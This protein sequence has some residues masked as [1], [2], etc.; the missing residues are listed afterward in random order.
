MQAPSRKKKEGHYPAPFD[1]ERPADQLHARALARG[2]A[3]LRIAHSFVNHG[4][5]DCEILC[6]GERRRDVDRGAYPEDPAYTAWGRRRLRDAD[7]RRASSQRPR[8]RPPRSGP[9]RS[10]AADAAPPCDRIRSNRNITAEKKSH[11]LRR[12]S[13][14]SHREL[15]RWRG[16]PASA[17]PVA[18]DSAD[19]GG[20]TVPVQAD[21][22]AETVASQPHERCATHPTCGRARCV[23]RGRFGDRSRLRARMAWND[24]ERVQ[25]AY[26]AAWDEGCPVAS[27]THLSE[28]ARV[29]LRRWRSSARRGVGED[30][31]D[32]RIRDLADGLIADPRTA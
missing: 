31:R 6:F 26:R 28:G 20:T 30:D 16:S 4:T 25:A 27:P 11:A 22:S 7:C 9:I 2:G 29:A 23:A 21:V 19:G 18:A 5:A 13:R 24:D 10:E 17:T 8:H 12:L 14:R 32:A 15:D 1:A 3:H